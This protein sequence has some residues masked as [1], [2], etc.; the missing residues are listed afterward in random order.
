MFTRFLLA[1]ALPATLAWAQPGSL[2]GFSDDGVFNLYVNEER[3]CRYTFQWKSDGSF[4]GNTVTTVAGQSTRSSVSITPGADGRWTTATLID[5]NERSLFEWAGNEVTMTFPKG[6]GKAKPAKDILIYQPDSPALITQ[7]LRRYNKAEGGSQEFALLNLNEGLDSLRTYSVTLQP[8]GTEERTIAG[9]KLQLIR[10]SYSMT[11]CDLRVLAGPDDRVYLVTG[12]PWPAQ[13]GLSEQ[14]SA[15]VREGYED[16][17][18]P[19]DSSPGVSQPK[20]QVKVEAGVRVPMR[21]GVNLST[22]IYLPIGAGKAPVILVRTPYRKEMDE[23]QARFFA[24]R[25]YVFAVQD[26]RGRFA[27]EGKWEPMVHEGRD[28]YDAIEWLARQPWASGKVGMIGG[29]YVGW[30]QWWAAVQHP[31]HLTT[32]IPNVSPPDPFRNMPF[33]FGTVGLFTLNWIDTVETNAT[34]NIDGAAMKKIDDRNSDEAI[35]ALPLLDLDKSVL[36][37]ESPMWRLFMAHS[38]LDSYWKPAMFLDQLKDVRIPVFHQSGWYD[39]DGIGTKLNYLKMASY[40]HSVQKLTVGP[41]GHSDT[42]RRVD[43]KRDFGPKASI[44]LQHDYLRWFD[45]WLKGQDTGILTDPL[46]S[47]YVMESNKWLHG[48]VYPLPETRFQNL[49]LAGSGRMSFTAPPDGQSPD[50]YTY[51]PGDPTPL[52]ATGEGCEK[53]EVMRK[54]ALVFTTAPFD[55]PYT[56]AG[57]VSA[58]LYAASSARDTD[59]FVNLLD[60]DAGG[61]CSHLWANG[62]GRIRA[63]YRNSFAHPEM[64]Q[65]GKI[66]KYTLDLWHTA[67]TLAPGH[68]LKVVVSSAGFPSFSRN[69]NTGGNNETE[70]LFVSADQTIY[71]DAKHPSHIVLPMIPEK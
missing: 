42:A 57:P 46:V 12:L 28:G 53:P 6:F 47:L 61:K 29:S 37:R 39:G 70:L 33:D 23:L 58:E 13:G 44:D 71:H 69:L 34:G 22:D 3:L 64:L 52:A 15:I 25:G 56:I 5:S 11:H 36:G 27:S 49:Y 63:R 43:L 24:R 66:Y 18:P 7:A 16:L 40:G 10:W 17:L 41:W 67:A 21:D 35:R 54:D 60:V 59:W 8:H 9:R 26:V 45:Y 51:D 50:H 30:V 20:Y 19:P 62:S 38:A 1:L 55:K 68:R 4:E 32:I 2:S 14:H 48:N 65:P 31:P